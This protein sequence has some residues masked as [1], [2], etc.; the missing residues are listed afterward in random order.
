MTNSLIVPN[1]LLREP[2]VSTGKVFPTAGLKP[3]RFSVPLKVAVALSGVEWAV[4]VT[5]RWPDWFAAVPPRSMLTGPTERRFAIAE[6]MPIA[7][8]MATVPPPLARITPAFG[9]V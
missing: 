1:C 4:P 9:S 3:L 2:K 5:L 8:L 7:P 6:R